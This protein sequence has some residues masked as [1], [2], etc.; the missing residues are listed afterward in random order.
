MQKL[1]VF[2]TGGTIDKVYFDAK[3]EYEVGEAMIG[4]ILHE[5]GVTFDFDIQELLKK[6]SLDLDEQDRQQIHEAVANCAEQHILITHGT[7]TMAE[8]GRQL[9]DIPGKTIVLVGSLSP[10]RF[11][12]S[13][14]VFN[15]GCAV[16]A[17]QTLPPGVYVTMSGRVFE[18]DK[19]RKNR[20]MNRFEDA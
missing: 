9:L 6:D 15:I 19:V 7:D 2:T 17:V 11:Q 18:A 20:D 12:G 16:A 4:R 1:Q 13:D 10:A 3:S 5:V 8:T 14:A